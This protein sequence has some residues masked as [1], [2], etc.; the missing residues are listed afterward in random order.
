[1]KLRV[2]AAVATAAEKK[3]VSRARRAAILAFSKIPTAKK[4]KTLKKRKSPYEIEIAFIS[5]KEIRDLNR[6]FRGKNRPTDVLSFAGANGSTQ[7]GQLALC[8]R[9]IRRQAKEL[10]I[11]K[12][13]ELERMVIHG[14]LHLFGYDHEKSRAQAK[15]MFRLQEQLLS[16]L[17]VKVLG[18]NFLE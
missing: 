16:K 13:E 9:V 15:V 5:E 8:W 11:P 17:R 7:I 18:G 14:V 6:R 2:L 1:M 4:S 3:L 12:T 10:D